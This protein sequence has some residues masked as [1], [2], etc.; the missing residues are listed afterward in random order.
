MRRLILLVALSAFAVMAG[1]PA[2]A[3]DAPA[4]APDKSAFTVFDPTPP[5]DLRMLCPD[6]PSKATG[7]CTV[8][9]GHW[10]VETDVY[11]ITSQTSGGVTTRME[12]FAAPTLKLGLTNTLDIEA[13][14][15]PWEQVATRDRATGLATTAGGVG[16]LFLHA[17]LNLAGDDGGD[18]AFALDPY[19]KI[20]TAPSSLG[21]GRI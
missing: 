7:A 12:V 15:A 3:G 11:D 20:P 9:A 6:R 17:K 4:P 8:D 16:D 2:W 13:T 5:A 18:V 21:N 19:V 14:I 10:Q 1:A